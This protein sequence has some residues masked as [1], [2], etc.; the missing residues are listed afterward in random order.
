MLMNVFLLM[1]ETSQFLLF[2]EQ[3]M[4]DPLTYGHTFAAQDGGSMKLQ[5]IDGMQA[6]YKE[7]RTAD[8]SKA[9]MRKSILG[10]SS[11]NYMASFPWLLQKGFNLKSATKEK[12]TPQ[13]ARD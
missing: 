10:R 3:N 13:S 6:L 1:L 7:H 4:S 9:K 2:P 5:E 12:I 11:A 8:A